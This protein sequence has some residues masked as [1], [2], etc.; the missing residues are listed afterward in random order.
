MNRLRSER[1]WV[2]A[3]AMP[4]LAAC[5]APP[6]PVDA[7]P[8][9]GFALYRSGLLSHA[10]IRELC[11]LGV[12]EIL[13]L[14]GEAEQQECRLRSEECPGLRVRYNLAQEEDTPVAADFLRAFDAWIDEARSEGRKVAFRCRHGWHRTGRLAAYYRLRFGG[15][16]AEEATGEMHE[17]G[18]L[19]FR[20]PT[21]GPQVAAYADFVAGRACS[22]DPA[23]CVSSEPDPG[24]PSGRFPADVCGSGPAA[25][26]D[27][28]VAAWLV[29]HQRE[30]GVEQG[31]GDR[32][33]LRPR[34]R[35]RHGGLPGDPRPGPAD[36]AA[37]APVPGPGAG[38]RGVG[39]RVSQRQTAPERAAAELL[40]AAAL[41][42][43]ADR[44]QRGRRD[45]GRRLEGDHR[46]A[47][48]A[49][50]EAAGQGPELA[51]A[52][53]GHLAEWPVSGPPPGTLP[54]GGRRRATAAG[55]EGHGGQHGVRVP[56]RSCRRRP[57]AQG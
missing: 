42:R 53:P 14:D 29:R 43:Q 10:E 40:L 27:D 19:M 54:A 16:S 18:R 1:I 20:H 8:S 30:L 2:L 11:A 17:I 44:R 57:G 38:G 47:L 4:L 21:L 52:V 33:P 24:V 37:P 3:L 5:D 13:V 45:R 51:Q 36:A 50:Q 22:T 32:L 39:F 6:R 46:G 35:R 12:E 25:P 31:V 56:G 55:G 41:R 9:S 48:P 34:R 26:A 49:A 7:D 28:G 15:A 23:R